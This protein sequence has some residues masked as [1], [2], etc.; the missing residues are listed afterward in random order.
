MKSNYRPHNGLD[1]MVRRNEDRRDS[2]RITPRI[3]YP[4]TFQLVK[5]TTTISRDGHMKT[6]VYEMR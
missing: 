2:N 4:V 1:D 5:S 6:I 3:N